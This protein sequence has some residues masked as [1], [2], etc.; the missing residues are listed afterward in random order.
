MSRRTI[1]E[2]LAEAKVR[3]KQVSE[4]A[5]KQKAREAAAAKKRERQDDTNRK[6][7]LGGLVVL[8]QLADADKGFLLGALL[9]AATRQQEP[10]YAGKCKSAGDK[11]L[12]QQANT[13]RHSAAAQ[14]QE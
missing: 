6:I 5:R 1:D 11:L 13:S 4:L 14:T 8:A 2:R 3:L 12:A 9:D 10:E 7:R